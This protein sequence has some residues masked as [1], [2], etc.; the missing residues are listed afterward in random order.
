VTSQVTRWSYSGLAGGEILL[1]HGRQ[2]GRRDRYGLGPSAC[3]AESQGGAIASW[4]VA[5]SCSL[6]AVK[7]GDRTG[8]DWT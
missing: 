1:A 5:K 4:Q 3:R 7:M 8:M 2:D 6:M